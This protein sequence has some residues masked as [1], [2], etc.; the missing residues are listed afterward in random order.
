MQYLRGL[1]QYCGTNYKGWQVQP[2]CLTIQKVLQD[3]ISRITNETIKVKAAGRT[4]AGAHALGQVIS[5][6]TTTGLDPSRLKKAINALLPPDIRLIDLT[7]T[8]EGF[9][10]RYD[11]KMKSY[12]Y[13]IHLGQETSPFIAPFVWDVRCNLNLD[14]LKEASRH[15]I[16]SHD[17]SGF[18]AS[19]SEVSNTVRTVYCID[20]AVIN[21]IPFLGQTLQND[22]LAI[23]V[24]ANGFLKQMV[25][26]I[27]GTLIDIGRGHLCV[28]AIGSILNSKDRK[29]AGITAPAR[30]LYLKAVYY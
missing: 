22:L 30:G 6:H 12:L 25:R 13:L 20:I 8:Y 16:G 7:A 3:V 4:D 27:V 19:G 24:T 17:F 11:A 18:M 21:E 26:N 9:H 1:L 10:P 2:N 15:L 23:E 28:G 5:F 14:K 29:R